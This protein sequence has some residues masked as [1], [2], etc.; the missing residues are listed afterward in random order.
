M[1]YSDS[2]TSPCRNFVKNF[3]FNFDP[4]FDYEDHFPSSPCFSYATHLYNTVDGNIYVCPTSEL[5]GTVESR[6]MA[7]YWEG[8]GTAG[9]GFYDN[10]E[11]VQKF[12]Y[13]L[14]FYAQDT[15]AGYFSGSSYWDSGIGDYNMAPTAKSL[16]LWVRS[17]TTIEIAMWS[18]GNV[19]YPPIPTTPITITD[20]TYLGLTTQLISPN[21]TDF[22]AEIIAPAGCYGQITFKN[23]YGK[24]SL[25]DL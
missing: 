18:A 3:T 10:W 4:P 6:A 7:G 2:I 9:C 19:V 14:H 23:G 1:A 13:Y 15:F 16:L 8:D 24:Y 11:D 5:D 22:S 25:L 21:D 20:P 12:P 17:A